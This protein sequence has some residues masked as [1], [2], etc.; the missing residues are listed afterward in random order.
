MF[1]ICLAGVPVEIDNRYGYVEGLCADYMCGG[2]EIP[3]FRVSVTG[4]QTEAYLR[5]C[6]RPLTPPEA[7]SALLYRQICGHMPAYDALLLHA[8]VLDFEGRGYAFSARR[9]TGKTTHIAQW[10][11]AYGDRVTVVNGDKPLVRRQEDGHWRIYGTPWCGKEGQQTNT[12][13]PLKALC[14]LEQGPV[15][16]MVHHPEADTVVRLLEATILPPT[17]ALQDDMATL[18]GMLTRDIPAFLL[19]CLPHISAAELACATLAAV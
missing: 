7:E 18:V 15:N 8:A 3:A 13:V 12:S 17:K 10:Q 14:F 19:T 4:A 16:R 1:R 6:G 11:A 5:T 9:G 2:D